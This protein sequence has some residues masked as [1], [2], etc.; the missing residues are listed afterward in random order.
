MAK[1]RLWGVKETGGAV[2]IL[3]TGLR[4]EERGYP[5]YLKGGGQKRPG[6]LLHLSPRKTAR[7]VC[8]E[9]SDGRL[10]YL[11]FD[12]SLENILKIHGRVP[13]PP[14]IRGGEG[15]DRDIRDYQT[16]FARHLGS[17]AAPTAGLHFDSDLF[18]RLSHRNIESAFIT[19]HIGASTF[20]PVLEEDITDHPL[21]REEYF[22]EEEESAKIEK[23]KALFA[24]G[25]TSLR[26]LESYFL[27]LGLRGRT[28]LFLYP[29]VS[30]SKAIGGLITNF[31]RPRSTLL[32]LVS[33]LIGRERTLALYREAALKRYRFY[34]YGD[35]M[36]ILRKGVGRGLL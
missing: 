31:H 6:A 36:L 28:D 8:R 10:F 29:G 17:V 24:V 22:I 5:A 11:R 12:D 35:A 4:Q 2:E 33:S 13:L 7:I 30:V 25:T 26:A 18:G 16:V 3:P 15:D 27:G 21:H 1:A 19:L 23:A 9:K 32:M 14:Y 34:S 20:A